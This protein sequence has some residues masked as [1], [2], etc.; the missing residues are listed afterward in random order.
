[1]KKFHKFNDD[2]NWY[3]ASIFCPQKT[4]IQF[5]KVE[6]DIVDL[7]VATDFP[8][9]NWLQLFKAGDWWMY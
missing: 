6:A 4:Q 8:F 5:T 2:G 9:Y 3:L 7:A 1:M